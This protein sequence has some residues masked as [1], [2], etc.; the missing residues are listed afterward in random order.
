VTGDQRHVT[1]DFGG[2]G[3]DLHDGF[4]FGHLAGHVSATVTVSF[5]T[6]R[7]GFYYCFGMVQCLGLAR[8]LAARNVDIAAMMNPLRVCTP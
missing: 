3:V 5:D 1:V 7:G 8:G 2:A 6:R 4:A